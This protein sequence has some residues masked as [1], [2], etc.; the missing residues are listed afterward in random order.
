MD[1]LA[2]ELGC[3]RLEALQLQQRA[4]AE[5]M[6]YFEGKMPVT[7]DMT[8]RSD[9]HLVVPGLNAPL[10]DDLQEALSIIVEGEQIQGDDDA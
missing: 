3:T 9:V 8:A 4:A 2:A 7:I 6:P 5:L 10:T 1:V